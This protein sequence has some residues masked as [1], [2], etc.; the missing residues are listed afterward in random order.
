MVRIR[1][2]EEKVDYLFLQGQI[3]G[4]IYQYQGQE[5]VAVG[6]C[7]ALRREDRLTST[8][9]PRGHCIAKGVSINSMMA[10][11]FAKATGC[12]KSKGGSMHMGDVSVGAIPAIA[13][14]A[15]G[16]T[17]ATEMG[18]AFKLPPPPTNNDEQYR[19]VCTSDAV[20][21]AVHL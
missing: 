17:V 15:G 3:V 18:L 13:I 12:C 1:K 19:R 10:E 21:H 6:A 7:S 9:R 14:V 11:L 4:T 5:A 2:F 20:A 16:V 8:R